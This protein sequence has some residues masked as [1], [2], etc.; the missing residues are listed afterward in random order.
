MEIKTLYYRSIYINK[1]SGTNYLLVILREN[2]NTRH[3][4]KSE[5]E[6]RIGKYVKFKKP[7]N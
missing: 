4:R 2:T 5:I 6:K 1:D 7:N 3:P